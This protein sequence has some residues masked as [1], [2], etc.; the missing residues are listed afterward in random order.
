MPSDLTT[1]IKL[2]ALFL[3]LSLLLVFISLPLPALRAQE[4]K[5]TEKEAV[6][7]ANQDEA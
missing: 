6:E 3:R 5:Q 2:P 4:E 7:R 1:N